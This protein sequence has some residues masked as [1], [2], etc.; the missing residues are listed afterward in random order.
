MRVFRREA[1]SARQSVGAGVGRSAAMCAGSPEGSQTLPPA[2][3]VSSAS[4][5]YPVPPRLRENFPHDEISVPPS[6]CCCGAQGLAE[7]GCV[8]HSLLSLARPL[9]GGLGGALI[10]YAGRCDG[11]GQSAAAGAKLQPLGF[12][13]PNAC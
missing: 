8:R 9:P 2:E 4:L 6:P 12:E 5:G 3:K 11:N 10:Q 7:P 1:T 13:S